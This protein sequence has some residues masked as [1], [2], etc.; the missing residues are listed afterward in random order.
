[1]EM[2]CPLIVFHEQP[3]FTD[4]TEYCPD[5]PADGNGRIASGTDI[6]SYP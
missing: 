1:M 6:L 4:A 2:F 5:G 3:N